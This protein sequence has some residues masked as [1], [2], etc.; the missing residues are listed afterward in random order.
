MS[1]KLTKAQVAEIE[2]PLPSVDW[3]SLKTAET[4][5]GMAFTYSNLF[6]AQRASKVDGLDA[7]DQEKKR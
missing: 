6:E 5:W 7:L 4:V 2:I 1:G 3:G